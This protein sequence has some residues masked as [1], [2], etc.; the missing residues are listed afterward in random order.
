[1]I[2]EAGAQIV[3]PNAKPRTKRLVPNAA[4][5]FPT[6]SSSLAEVSPAAKIALFRDATKVPLHA[7]SEIM[8]L[9]IL[10]A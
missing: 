10:S 2:S 3:G 7:I 9:V 5:S 4:T 6:W 8:N 1:M